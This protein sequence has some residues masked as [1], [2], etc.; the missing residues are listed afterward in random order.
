M[1]KYKLSIIVPVYNEEQDIVNNLRKI[2]REVLKLKADI[3]LFIVNDGSTDNTRILLGKL[4]NKLNF[5]L[6]N[7]NNKGYG[8][9]IKIGAKKA[10]EQ[11][12]D[13][14]LFMDS[15][16]TNPPEFIKDFLNLITSGYDII[17]ADRFLKKSNMSE[18]PF[19]RRMF[20]I[21]A[22]FVASLCFRLGIR[23]YTNGFRAINL[24]KFLSMKL[25]ENHFPII[26]EEM[27][28]VKKFNLK[29][30]NIT[31]TLKSRLEGSKKSSFEYDIKTLTSYLKYCIMSIK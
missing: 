15:D 16:L 19:K 23:D 14:G 18:V 3:G 17:K 6:I 10:F 20:S 11:G 27:Y 9:A 7:Q 22:N 5:F 26:M 1:A 25:K 30:T 2:S 31:T 24:K 28:Y 29:I 21:G 12:Y 4:E 13:Y 8:G